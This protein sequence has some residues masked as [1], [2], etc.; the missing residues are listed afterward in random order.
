MRDLQRVPGGF[1][2]PG[3]GET[4][5]DRV[6]RSRQGTGKSFLVAAVLCLLVQGVLLVQAWQPVFAAQQETGRGA[7]QA[8]NPAA[9]PGVRKVQTAGA[10]TQRLNLPPRVR[11]VQRFLARREWTPGSSRGWATRR[12]NFGPA[13]GQPKAAAQTPAAATWK[14]VGPSSVLTPTYGQVTGRVSALALD[15]SDATGNLL[16]LGTTG[17]GVWVAPN[18]AVTKASQVV[19]TPLTD[20]VE[21]LSIAQDASISIGALTVQPGGA[22]VILAGTGDPNDALDS[23]YG[24][25]ILRSADAGNSWSLIGGTADMLYSFTGEGFAGFAWSTVNPQLVVA[26]VSQAYEG[27]LVNAQAPNRSYEG[28]YYSNDSGITWNLATIT[29]G[30]GEVVQQAG[31]AFSQPDGNAATAVEWNPVRQMFVAAVRFHGYYQSTDGM[32][33]TRMA[34]QPGVGLTAARL[35]YEFDWDRLD[36]LPHLRGALAVN[37]QTGDTFAWTV[38]LNNQDQGLWQDQCAIER[39]QPAPIQTITFAQQLNTAALETNTAGG[40]ATIANGDYNLALA[41]VPSRAGHAAAGRGQRPVEVQPGHGLRVAQ[42]HQCQHLHERAGGLN[43]STRWPG[44][45]TIRWRFLWATTAA[46]GARPTGSARRARC[47][48]RP[49]PHTFRT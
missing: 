3:W 30:A 46:C 29:D 26:A 44:P 6:G 11:Q 28:L 2:R 19:F 17:G 5:L 34:A 7:S 37:P 16:Y 1:A 14:P 48:R 42:Y 13:F 36:R 21:G 22:G 31:A 27:T 15:P 9:G 25:G 23:Y 4:G 45:R 49:M 18:A 24:A 10:R 33:W 12:G 39:G 8:L 35:P 32:T 47:A 43:T 41:A 38:D 20:T 40:A